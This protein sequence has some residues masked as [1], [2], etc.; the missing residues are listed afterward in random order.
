MLKKRLENAVLPSK[1]RGFRLLLAVFLAVGFMYWVCETVFAEDRTPRNGASNGIT[2]DVFVPVVLSSPGLVGS[3]YTTELTFTNRGNTTANVDLSYTATNGGGTG[4]ASVSLPPGQT[5]IPNAIDYLKTLG[6]PISD[7]GSLLG[8]LRA[9][10]SNLNSANEVN[11]M[12]RTTTEVKDGGGTVVGR[13]G[14]AYPALSL[15]SS[16]GTAISQVNHVSGNLPGSINLPN[17]AKA[18]SAR[19]LMMRSSISADCA[20]LSPTGTMWRFKTWALRRMEILPWRP[21]LLTGGIG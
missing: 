14:L 21:T 8:T 1:T 17:S 9:H 5:V 4:T 3:F 6:L 20:V 12:A 13:A 2:A 18:R 11:I 19:D 7:S 15:S 16:G 10:F